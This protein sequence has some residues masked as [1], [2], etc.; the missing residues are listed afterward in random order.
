VW[1]IVLAD[2]GQITNI[3]VKIPKC[4]GKGLN[5][6]LRDLR[7]STDAFFQIDFPAGPFYK[8]VCP[9]TPN[10]GTALSNI[11]IFLHTPLN[12]L[13]FWHILTFLCFVRNTNG[14]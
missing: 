7:T 14:F 1:Q 13:I 4:K 9:I 10:P 3:L 2:S 12:I 11:D 8:G 5:D 6:F